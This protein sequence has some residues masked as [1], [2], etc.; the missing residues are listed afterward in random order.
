MGSGKNMLEK[1]EEEHKSQ[2]ETPWNSGERGEAPC[3]NEVWKFSV[4]QLK[5]QECLAEI[6]KAVQQKKI[7]YYPSFLNGIWEQLRFQSISYWGL[8]AGVLFMALLLI[9]YLNRHGTAEKASITVCSLFMVFAG[10]IC[11]SGVGR[12]FSWH[13]AELEQT[14]YLNLKQMVCIQMLAAG[15]MDLLVLALIVVFCGSRYDGGTGIY[16]LYLLVPFLWS[17]I[18]YL[19]MLTIFRGGMR[20]YRQLSAAVIC[21][22]L[23]VLPSLFEDAYYLACLPAWVGFALLGAGILAMEIRRLLGKIEGGDGLCLN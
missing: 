8:Q 23:A 5:K 3:R 6:D 2:G 20:G 16:L 1:R 11:L 13:M 15:I 12:L 18:L 21:G 17:D 9:A 22:I 19:H 7:R 14:L 10:N 4:N